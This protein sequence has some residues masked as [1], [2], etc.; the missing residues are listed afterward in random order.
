MATILK[1]IPNRQNV[2]VNPVVRQYILPDTTRNR[3]GQMRR[4]DTVLTASD[5]TL[6]INSE[7]F[8]V[9]EVLFRPE[10]VGQCFLNDMCLLPQSEPLL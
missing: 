1:S 4:A 3:H 6:V 10:I 7:R 5:Q 2:A 9:P 8:L